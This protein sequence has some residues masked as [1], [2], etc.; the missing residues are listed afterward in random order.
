MKTIP[1]THSLR[2][3]IITSSIILVL[4]TAAAAGLPALWLIRQQLDNQAW[5]QIQQ[6]YSAAQSLYATRK[7]QITSLAA[8]IAQR[9]GLGELL[10]QEDQ[11]ALEDYLKGM[12]SSEGLDLIAVCDSSQSLLAASASVQIPDGICDRRPSGSFYL[13]HGQTLPQVWL[14]ATHSLGGA[15]SGTGTVITGFRLDNEFAQ[16]MRSQTGLEHSLLAN[17]QVVATSLASP[18]PVQVEAAPRT[19]VLSS[20][21]TVVCCSYELSD[22]SYYAARLP[23]DGS[24][25]QAEIALPVTGIRAAQWK[26]GLVLAG[27]MLAVA[28]LGSVLS[29]MRARQISKPLTALADAANRFSQGDLTSPV[30]AETQVREV[31]QVSQALEQARLDLSKSLSALQE[32]KAWVGH[33]LD[34]I[35][36][37]IVTLDESR[38]ITFF[39][40]GAEQI[41][42]RA[43]AEALGRVCDEVFRAAEGDPPFS[44]CI[45]APGQKTQIVIQAAADRPVVLSITRA[46]LTPPGAAGPEIALVFR[47]VSEEVTIHR[48]LGYFIAN[49]AHEFRTPLSAL[50]ASIELLMD[51]AP[52]FS[53]AEMDELL[54]TLHLG[55][56]SLQT[57]VDNLLES[58]SIEAGH[59]RVSPRPN[60]LTP[61][62]QEAV[63]TM[64]P[65]LEK[66]EQRLSLDT[67]AELPAVMADP[68]RIVQVLVNLLSNASRYGPADEITLTAREQGEGVIVRVADRGPGVSG[69]QR[70]LLFRRFEHPASAGA[71]SKVG[72]GLGLSVVKAI[73]EAHGGKTGVDDRP[74]GGSIFWFTLPKAY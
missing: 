40:R 43:G 3:Q 21:E 65:L 20:S 12:Q 46:Q 58:A 41:T 23:V 5:S 39:S 6:G 48:L 44:Q 18:P 15:G 32:E 1:T 29:F 53:P 55:V 13:I 61:L 74:G 26:L 71:E 10:G 49:I 27:S 7:D 38:K 52:D 22:Q 72:A 28:A 42:G 73:V 33:L 60:D 25:I 34:S 2:A 24:G 51:Q 54:K 31:V 11:A 50:A 59:F 4:I 67:P 19:L 30:Q 63:D 69:Q 64:H 62:I 37:G 35:V 47:D 56:L 14:M 9:P 66:Y 68:R 8:L 70:E 36:E 16:Q 45:P 57:L 17:D